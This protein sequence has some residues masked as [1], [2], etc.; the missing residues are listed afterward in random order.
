MGGIVAAETLLAITSDSPIPPPPAPTSEPKPS[1]AAHTMPPSSSSADEASASTSSSSPPADPEPPT[2]MFPHIAGILAFD[3]PYLGISPGVIAHGA[4]THYRTASSAWSAVSE[5]ASVLGYGS[6]TKS[7]SSPT[8]Q[9][10][11]PSQS[12][13]LTQGAD[14]MTASMSA[15]S[16]DAAATPT[17]QR[18]GK[19]AMFAGAAGAV[20]AGGAAAYLKRDSITEG[21]SW[22]G[23]HLEFVGCLAR[24]EDLKTRLEKVAALNRERGIGFANLVTVLGKAA[25]PQK[26]DGTAV[27]GTGGF[28]EIGASSSGE[29]TGA[30]GNE[31]TFCTL[32]KSADNRVF[33]ERNRNDR[34]R[35][36]TEA[37][38]E[39]FERKRNTG[40]FAMAE[41]AKQLVVS[42][43]ERGEWYLDSEPLASESELATGIGDGLGDDVGMEDVELSGKESMED[44]ELGD[45][46]VDEGRKEG[47]AWA[48]DEPVLVEK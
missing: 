5:V 3:T 11:S 46:D 42:W 16:Q 17:W 1:Q 40:Y 44:V 2:F 35:D 7:P 25:Q 34:A 10:Q 14:A 23:S 8:S 9:S 22:I 6:S 31:R 28:V 13:M 24:G 30:G 20:A 38:M 12:K 45:M 41:R 37:H 39:M 29:G 19:Y 36:E 21:W 15:S 47:K 32:P 18:W 27:P 26:K 48:G 43:V 4:E 33:F